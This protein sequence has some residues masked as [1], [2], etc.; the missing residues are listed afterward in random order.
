MSSSSRNPPLGP[1]VAARIREW[2]HPRARGA[3]VPSMEELLAQAR[4]IVNAEQGVIATAAALHRDI[5]EE[6][7]RMGGGDGTMKRKAD[8]LR[9]LQEDA[10]RHAHLARE[11]LGQ[12][13]GLAGGARENLV[14]HAAALRR[15]AAALHELAR[16]L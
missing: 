13:G 16:K 14:I 2:L 9:Q 8:Q 12:G 5:D 10:S 11:L 3:S 15:D 1:R 4:A 6:W 7:K